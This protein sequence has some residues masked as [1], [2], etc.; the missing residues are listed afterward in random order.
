MAQISL[1]I[2]EELDEKLTD[3]A[4]KNNRSRSNFIMNL[5]QEYIDKQ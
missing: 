5:L 1:Y 2:T 3:H 4:R